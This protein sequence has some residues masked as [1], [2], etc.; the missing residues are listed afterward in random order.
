MIDIHSHLL[1]GVDDGAKSIEESLDILADLKR[2]GYTDVILTPHY[3]KDSHYDS[4]RSE[5]LKR[6]KVLKE[7]LKNNNI[8]I[9][10]YLGNEIYID[11]DIEEFLNNDI[12]SS[13]NDSKFLL[14]E[15]PMSG[16]YPNYKEIFNYLIK[17]NYNVILAHPERY[18]AFQK[19]FS[20]V[21]EL[22]DIGV[23]FQCNIESINGRYGKNA[24][25][26]IK[27]LLKNRKINFLATDIHHKRNNEDF[28]KSKKSILKY[29]KEEE[30]NIL[31]YENPSK[32]I[33]SK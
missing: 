7:E 11:D 12:I 16:E 2:L 21:E 20:K 14:I 18:L 3:I 31:T 26:T 13:L 4:K 32:I 28:L 25:K 17:K 10:V 27:K 8:D 30:F 29:I 22:S 24:K 1:Y 23:Y 5:N 6:L 19:D 15:L 9:N 33:K